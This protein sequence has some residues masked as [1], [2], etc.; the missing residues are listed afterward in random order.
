MFNKVR[1]IFKGYIGE[2]IYINKTTM[3]VVFL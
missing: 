2:A 3:T 1:I